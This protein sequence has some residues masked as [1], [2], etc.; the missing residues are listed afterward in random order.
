MIDKSDIDLAGGN[1]FED[2]G[3]LLVRNRFIFDYCGEPCSRGI[4]TEKPSKSCDV[5]LE[6]RICRRPFDAALPFRVG[7]VNEGFGQVALRERFGVV[8]DCSRPAGDADPVIRWRNEVG[9]AYL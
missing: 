3:V 8:D 1:C 2:G 5:V 4:V 6:R 9:V 7:E